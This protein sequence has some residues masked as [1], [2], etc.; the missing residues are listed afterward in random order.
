MPELPTFTDLVGEKLRIEPHPPS[1]DL[2]QS[3]YVFSYIT[4]AWFLKFYFSPSLV[5]TYLFLF[6]IM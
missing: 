2:F 4:C 3:C 5:S 6:L 1:S